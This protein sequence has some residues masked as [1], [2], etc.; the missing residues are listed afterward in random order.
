MTRRRWDQMVGTNL[1]AV[2]SLLFEEEIERSFDQAYEEYEKNR[3]TASIDRARF[4]RALSEFW[5]IYNASTSKIDK[6]DA[7]YL[8]KG[9]RVLFPFELPCFV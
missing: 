8:D 6:Y 1:S 4:R 9:Y 7:S 3:L 5:S 2:V